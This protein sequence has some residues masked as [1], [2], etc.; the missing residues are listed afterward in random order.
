MVARR[1]GAL[2]WIVC[3][4]PAYLAEH[5]TP[6]SPQDL[7]KHNCIVHKR[8]AS[9]RIW[10][11]TGRRSVKVSGSFATNS[12]VIV[13]KAALS[14]TGIAQLPTYFVAE[15]LR[16]GR[17]VQMPA[18]FDLPEGVVFALLPNQRAI[19]RRVRLF[20]SFLQRWYRSGPWNKP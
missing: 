8:L 16:A 6:K 9:E 2:K 3:A 13:H 15:D 14:G 1:L 12:D 10:R 19:S 4:S 20:L 18:N 17:L 7:A 5:G 11:F